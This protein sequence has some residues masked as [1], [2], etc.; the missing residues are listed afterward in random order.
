MNKQDRLE[1]ALKNDDLLA[2]RGSGEFAHQNFFGA[3]PVAISLAR[4]ATIA[5]HTAIELSK[6]KGFNVGQS[7]RL[8]PG[9]DLRSTRMKTFCPQEPRCLSTKYRRPDGSCN[10]RRNRQWGKSMITFERLLEADY[11]DGINDPRVSVDGNSLPSARDVSIALA[12]DRNQPN[13]QY[14]LMVMQLGQFIDHDLTHTASTRTND[15]FALRCCGEEFRRNPQL[16]HPSCFP[17]IVSPNDPFYS[18]FGQTCMNFVRSAPAIRP[19][20]QMGPRE[21]LN[22]LTAYL[23]ASNIYGSTEQTARSLRSLRNGRLRVSLVNRR[24]FL[25]FDNNTNFCAIPQQQQLQCFV[26]GDMR[27]NEQTELTVMHTV[28]M[29]EHNRV[30]EVLSELNPGWS[31]EIIYQEA[32]RVVTAEFQHIIFNEFLPIIIGR[33]AMRAFRLLLKRN[34]YSNTY[35]EDINAGITSSFATAAFR[36]H[37]LIEGNIRLIND[38]NRQVDRVDLRTQFN[39][40]QILYKQRALDLM[41]NGLTGQPIQHGDN[42]FTSEVTNHLFEPIGQPFGMDLISLNIQR[43]RDHGLPSYN[44]FRQVCGLRAIRNFGDLSSVMNQNAVQA[45]NQVYRH[46]DDIDL[47]IGGV[48]EN[49]IN[50]GLVGP[51]FACIIAEQFRRLKMGDRFWFENGGLESSFN[52][53]QLREIKKS[54]LSRILCDNS[55]IRFMQPLALVQTFDWNPKLECR[56]N[57]IPTVDL[58]FWRNEPVW[59]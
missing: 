6:E 1:I 30:A 7:R 14:T 8:L 41:I 15:N 51:T 24:Q 22:Q 36:L 9:I 21:Q 12:P 27:V 4:D 3:N 19:N 26:A 23:D 32:K 45:I 54:S 47:F 55:D 10:N 20:C 44:R 49:P 42:F 28:W 58:T 56:G 34:D 29:R 59:T 13:R 35:S 39:N 25:P 48:S 37:T 18:N 33:P 53:I 11:S 31:D 40:P 5:L 2:K 46:V 16:V 38:N 43:G 57:D 17:I 52:E 50:G